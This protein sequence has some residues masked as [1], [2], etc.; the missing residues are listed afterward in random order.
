MIMDEY[1]REKEAIRQ[2][3]IGLGEDSLSKSYYPQLQESIH[4]LKE[5]KKALEKK[6]E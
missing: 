5:Q 6:T 1:L 4:E 3:V 2:K